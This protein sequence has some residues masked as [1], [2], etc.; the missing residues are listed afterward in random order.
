[1]SRR[2]SVAIRILAALAGIVGLEVIRY[3]TFS[4]EYQVDSSL[5]LMI[6]GSMRIFCFAPA[7]AEAF[8]SLMIGPTLC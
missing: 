6:A 1:M 2:H 3:F 8:Q 7:V 5:W 4:S